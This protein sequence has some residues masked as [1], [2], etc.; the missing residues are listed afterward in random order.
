[1][2]VG[3]HIYPVNYISIAKY[4]YPSSYLVF[5]SLNILLDFD[6]N[7]DSRIEYNFEN[8]GLL[9]GWIQSK[10]IKSNFRERTVYQSRNTLI[11]AELEY[12]SCKFYSVSVRM[13]KL[14]TIL[15]IPALV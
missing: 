11:Y 15:F 13:P 7:G 10:V 1:M 5:C 4:F 14:L 8:S 3:R 2:S 9:L 6:E 12:K